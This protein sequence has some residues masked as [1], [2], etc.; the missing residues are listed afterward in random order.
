MIILPKWSVRFGFKFMYLIKKTVNKI[1]MGNFFRT[2][3]IFFYIL[4]LTSGAYAQG[5]WD[6]L[7]TPIEKVDTSYYEKE[8]RIDFKRSKRDNLAKS[9]ISK[10]SIRGLLIGEDAITLT[11]FDEGITFVEKWNIYPDQGFLQD[12]F[13]ES[14]ADSLTRINAIILKKIVYDSVFVIADLTKENKNYKVELE[15]DKTFIKGILT[16]D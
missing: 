3:L 2:I 16:E 9:K 1:T 13:L 11:I 6:I 7:Y 12:Q 14:T 10:I 8:I 4:I 15:I 5:G